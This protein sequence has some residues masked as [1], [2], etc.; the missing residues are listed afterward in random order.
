LLGGKT[1]LAISAGTD[2]AK[3]AIS[4]NAAKN[5]AKT[6]SAAA[7]KSLAFQ[8]GIYGQQQQNFAPY[9]AQGQNAVQQ[10]GQRAAQPSPTFQ[11]GRPTS[12]QSPPQTPMASLGQPQQGMAPQGAQGGLWTIQAPDGTT[13]Q[14]PAQMAQQFVARG[15]K[16]VG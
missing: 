16:R 14:L 11:P 15:A 4:A 7:D 1:G 2:V 9:L 10:L 6:Q 3:A 12:F 5:A 13:K 8:Q